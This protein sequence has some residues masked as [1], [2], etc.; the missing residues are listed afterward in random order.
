MKRNKRIH[1]TTGEKYSV[2]LRVLSRN[3]DVHGRVIESS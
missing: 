3:G 1:K 2:S